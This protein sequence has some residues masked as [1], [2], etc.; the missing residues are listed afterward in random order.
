MLN[1]MS[2]EIIRKC[3]NS[4]LHCSSCSYIGATE[5]MSLDKFNEVI[6]DAVSLGVKTICLSGGEPFL[7]KDIIDFIKC[8]FYHN[9]DCYVYTSGIV[10]DAFGNPTAFSDD[11]MKTVSKY[12]KKL[13]FNM[14]A[15]NE[16]TY[17]LIMG[18]K[19]CFSKMQ[20]SIKKAIKSSILVEA[21]FVPMK[22]NYQEIDAVVELCTKLKVS[23]I[24]FLRLVLHGRAMINKE[25]LQ[26]TEEEYTIVKKKLNDLKNTSLTEIRIGV[27]LSDNN[28][29]I[30]CEAACGKLNIKYDGKV[31]PCEVFK[32]FTC[33]E[34]YFGCYP[35]SIYDER[36]KEIYDHSTYLQC[37]RDISKKYLNNN[38]DDLC[39]GQFLLN[40]MEEFTK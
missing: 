10:L 33:F 12:V 40:N 18:T 11:L 34:N 5:M 24:S 15:A 20:E 22:L 27:P 28:P 36:L 8:V 32:N 16:Q 17:G 37:V 9:V 23:R 19:N 13:I 35:N 21:H 3:P 7:H 39:V 38:S 26:L 4:C 31:Y 30:K 14:E 25:R 1:E 29:C 2:I 6:S